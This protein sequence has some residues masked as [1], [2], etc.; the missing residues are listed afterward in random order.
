MAAATNLPNSSNPQMITPN[1][2]ASMLQQ[3]QHNNNNNRFPFNS[4]VLT[5][6]SSPAP[7]KPGLET[8]NSAYSGED[9][10]GLR[11]SPS[12]FGIDSQKKKRGRPRK[13]SPDGGGS[14]IALGLAP[15]PISSSVGGTGGGGGG[16][17]GGA[18]TSSDKKNRGR[19]A[20]SSKLQLD[21]LGGFGL[22]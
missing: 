19:P 1:S 4:P 10:S 11:P 8:L 20:S 12:G 16:D 2:S 7:S 9:S 18:A 22:V 21:A 17:S 6:T 3:Q 15:T 5:T 14:N 13:Y